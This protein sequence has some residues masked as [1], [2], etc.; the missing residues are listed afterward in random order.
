MRPMKKKIRSGAKPLQQSAC[1]FAE[2]SAH[3]SNTKEKLNLN[4]SSPIYA[5]CT[6]KDRPLTTNACMPQYTGWK[7]NNFSVKFNG[8]DN[9]FKMRNGSLVVGT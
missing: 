3:I 1:R 7:T 5:R 4:S 9:C 2:N 6:L 8:A